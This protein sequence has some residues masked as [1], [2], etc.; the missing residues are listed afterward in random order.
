MAPGMGLNMDCPLDASDS[1]CGGVGLNTGWCNNTVAG[2]VQS[3]AVAD[4]IGLHDDYIWLLSH[5]NQPAL[6]K[7]NETTHPWQFHARKYP[8]AP[9]PDCILSL[10]QACYT[11]AL[12]ADPHDSMDFMLAQNGPVLAVLPLRYQLSFQ[13][14]LWDLEKWV[15]TVKTLGLKN[16]LKL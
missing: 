4:S 16:Y 11:T 5:S 13:N 8:F 7:W 3:L 14:S 12:L 9:N 10:L 6:Q 15:S 1:F 2:K